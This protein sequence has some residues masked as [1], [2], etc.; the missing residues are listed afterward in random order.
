MFGVRLFWFST[1][2]SRIFRQRMIDSVLPERV[3]NGSNDAAALLK[4]SVCWRCIK[5]L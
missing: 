2:L 5:D 1:S 3:E 4:P